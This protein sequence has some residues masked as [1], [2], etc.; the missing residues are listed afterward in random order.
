[1]AKMKSLYGPA[2]NPAVYFCPPYAGQP[3]HCEG[4]PGLLGLISFCLIAE[5][6][7]GPGMREYVHAEIRFEA[8]RPVRRPEYKQK[9]KRHA[10]RGKATEMQ[11]LTR[12]TKHISMVVV[13]SINAEERSSIPISIQV[14]STH[15]STGTKAREKLLM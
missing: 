4:D 5:N 6:L 7:F 3:A 9:G 12:A 10:Q 14:A 2:E 13:S 8:R 1:M 15:T 11:V